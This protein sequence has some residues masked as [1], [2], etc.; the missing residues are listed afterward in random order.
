MSKCIPLEDLAGLLEKVDVSKFS[1]DGKLANKDFRFETKDIPFSAILNTL[2]DGKGEFGDTSI[3]DRMGNLG[4]KLNWVRERLSK[5]DALNTIPEE[6]RETENERGLLRTIALTEVIDSSRGEAFKVNKYNADLKK[7]S[8]SYG[9]ATEIRMPFARVAA[10]IGR[11][12][13]QSRTGLVFGEGDATKASAAKIEQAYQTIGE[14]ALKD[15]EKAGFIKLHDKASVINDFAFTN[16]DGITR[17][18]AQDPKTRYTTMKAVSLNVSKDSRFR[19]LYGDELFDSY[20]KDIMDTTG[21]EDLKSFIDEVNELD[22]NDIKSYEL[23]EQY[24][25]LRNFNA[26]IAGVNRVAIPTTFVDVKTEAPDSIE[27]DRDVMERA[28]DEYKEGVKSLNETKQHVKKPILNFL[29]DLAEVYK[30]EKKPLKSLVRYLVGNNISTKDKQQF[31]EVLNSIFGLYSKDIHT[32]YS[33]ASIAGK[34]TSIL[35]PLEDMLG[36][37]DSITDEK[38]EPKYFHNTSHIGANGREYYD[39]AYLSIQANKIVR[40][41]ISVGDKEDKTFNIHKDK[42]AYNQFITYLMDALPSKLT[43]GKDETA[44]LQMLKGEDKSDKTFEYLLS[45]VDT[46]TADKAD[47]ADRLIA[48]G[49]INANLKGKD[50][51][52]NPSFMHNASVLLAV[53]DLRKA[54]EGDG[55]LTTDFLA[56]PDATA[57]GATLKL[58]EA[59]RDAN[60]EKAREILG[61]VG[62]IGDNKQVSDVYNYVNK[63]ILEP[64]ITKALESKDT[65][66]ESKNAPDGVITFSKKTRGFDKANATLMQKIIKYVYEDNMREFAKLPTMT[67]IYGQGEHASK[68]TIA[69]GVATKMGVMFHG[70]KSKKELTEA[71]KFVL[72]LLGED[73]D[74][75]DAIHLTEKDVAT[76]TNKFKDSIAANVQHLMK[77]AFYKKGSGALADFKEVSTDLFNLAQELHKKG[78]DNPK[79]NERIKEQKNKVLLLKTQLKEEKAKAKRNR[80]RKKLKLDK[81][82]FEKEDVK[83]M[84]EKLEKERSKLRNM[85]YMKEHLMMLPPHVNDAKVLPR[86]PYIGFKLEKQFNVYDP[87]TGTITN[88]PLPTQTV[89]DVSA[90]HMVD[91]Y[92]QVASGGHYLNLF[93]AKFLNPKYAAQAVKDYSEQMSNNINNFSKIESLHKTLEVYNDIFFDKDSKEHKQFANRIAAIKNKFNG[94]LEVNKE[95][96]VL[97]G[98]KVIEDTVDPNTKKAT[99]DNNTKSEVSITTFKSKKLSVEKAKEKIDNLKQDIKNNNVVTYDL[100]TDGLISKDGKTIPNVIQIGYKDGN[101]DIKTVHIK[102]PSKEAYNKYVNGMESEKIRNS[103]LFKEVSKGYKE[104]QDNAISI[105]EALK[106][107]NDVAKNKKTLTFNG[108]GFDNVIMQ[109]LFNEHNLDITP[110]KDSNT[111]DIREIDLGLNNYDTFKGTLEDKVNEYDLSSKE[112]QEN[113]HN[114]DFDVDMTYKLANAL[115]DVKDLNS[116]LNK[117]AKETDSPII[118]TFV[119]LQGKTKTKMR[120]GENSKFSSKQNTI[121]I[122]GPLDKT[123]VEHEILHSFTTLWIK[124]NKN[125]SSYKY[126]QKALPKLRELN[127]A[128]LKD[129]LANDDETAIAELISTMGSNMELAKKVYKTIDSSKTILPATRLR[130]VINKAI[131]AIIKWVGSEKALERLEKEGLNTEDLANA[132]NTAIG[133]SINDVQNR[134]TNFNKEVKAVDKT[135]NFMGGVGK[136]H[137]A[138]EDKVEKINALSVRVIT[139]PV[140]HKAEVIT[141]NVDRILSEKY[142]TYFRAKEYAIGVYNSSEA[143]QQLMQYI[144]TPEKLISRKNEVLTLSNKLNKETTD[145]TNEALNNIHHLTRDFSKNEKQVLGNITT[146][147]PLHYIYA[148][149]P[150]LKDFSGKIKELESNLNKDG[151]RNV[152]NIVS[153]W[154]DGVVK[155]TNLYSLEDTY[156]TSDLANNIKLLAALKA[157][158]KVDK[159]FELSTKIMDKHLDLYRT[160]KDHSMALYLTH[161]DI[162]ANTPSKIA[163]KDV[164]VVPHYNKLI[165]KKV[166]SYKDRDKMQYSDKNGWN[167]IQQP[168]KDGKIGIAY[169]EIID[170]QSAEGT[171]VELQLPETDI[172]VPEK[173]INNGYVDVHNNNIV[174][175]ADGYKLI[176]TAEQEKQIGILE[177]PAESL[178]RS[179]NNMIHLKETEVIRDRLAEK[180]FTAELTNDSTKE[181]A[182]EIQSK[183]IDHPWFLKVPDDINY[184]DLANSTDP[185]MRLIHAHYKPIQRKMSKVGGFDKK[186]TWVRKDVAHWLVGF[187][188]GPLFKSKLGQQ[189]SRITKNIVSLAKINMAIANPMKLV[190]DAASSVNQLIIMGVPATYIA[191]TSKDFFN[192]LKEFKRVQ[193]K[194]AALQLKHYADPNNEAITKNIAKLNEQLKDNSVAKASEH[195]FVNSLSSDVVSHNAQTRYGL[196][197]DVDN[198]LKKVFTK[199]GETANKLGEQILKLSKFG[200]WNGITALDR[201]A[202]YV[203]V[204]PGMEGKLEGVHTVMQELNNVRTEEDVVSMMRQWTLS[205]NSE[206]VKAGIEVNDFIDASSKYTYFKYLTEEKGYTEEEA[207]TEVM[208]AVPDYKEVMPSSMKLASDYGILMFP[209]YWTRIQRAIYMMGR[210]RPASL[211]AEITAAD[212]FDLSH[213]SGLTIL[214]SNIYDKTLDMGGAIHTPL[215][216]AKSGFIYPTHLI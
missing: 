9:N 127:I 50:Q 65:P 24:N 199:D 8:D 23:K 202:D 90:T 37:I 62:V 91:S 138:I 83:G 210:Y 76:L 40:D 105:D 54:V 213:L 174:H 86:N 124:D 17:I 173:Y 169:K 184:A 187:N 166:F 150:D 208:K 145:R 57:N 148:F 159:N 58:A 137:E 39:S 205:P 188:K 164:Q 100:E 190:K 191:K 94:K 41:I 178:V 93:D 112:N 103:K 183:V 71:H 114:A 82:N 5:P 121:Y 12:I 20:V 63:F 73:K 92:N 3:I 151:L 108:N 95:A 175:T 67:L 96:G 1:N 11:K 53:K 167:I 30:S 135:Y 146:K 161:K 88:K 7:V 157:L 4:Y 113:L 2:Q 162:L 126:L 42:E 196:T 29:K 27:N 128:E 116:E 19:K 85:L 117:L 107:F 18:A 179:T 101:K 66:E 45:K 141:K 163:M 131:K 172:T 78:K 215:Q 203:E 38:G 165:H 64:S 77:D 52:K 139:E 154:V 31:E 194:I 56:D 26:Y 181:I 28:T 171:G 16:E 142:P 97:F 55:T 21:D 134:A 80:R 129:I 120:S 209:S 130:N 200:G 72:D 168:T 158:E 60:N 69:K 197:A 10:V 216:A 155:D 185:N 48:L 122:A 160:I 89:F 46:L 133:K 143:L 132:I 79:F 123:V 170:T 212:I 25:K 33:K 32:S 61:A 140:E 193:T 207:V 74:K 115:I 35:S 99:L 186:V 177:T 111:Y 68:L 206:F 110:F 152:D 119:T 204:I 75:L 192:D 153:L 81:T 109:S 44:I 176:L 147:I 149:A 211:I 118:N 136:I 6:L 13:M 59:A 87:K 106:M 125:D 182:N 189:I 104:W 84:S 34:N 201:V 214:D 70:I 198:V 49:E 156:G 144:A 180:A 102:F 14:A 15:L 43:E 195:G 36:H 22:E 51:V 98:E 47:I